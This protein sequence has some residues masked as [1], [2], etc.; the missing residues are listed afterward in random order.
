MKVMQFKGV[1]K[2]HVCRYSEQGRK[3]KRNVQV[4]AFHF[5]RKTEHVY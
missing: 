5:S 1:N 2:K 3:E 4:L